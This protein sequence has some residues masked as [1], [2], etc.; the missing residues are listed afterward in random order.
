MIDYETPTEIDVTATFPTLPVETRTRKVQAGQVTLDES[1]SPFIRA[2]FTLPH[3]YDLAEDVSPLNGDRVLLTVK[4]TEYILR[5]RTF[6][7]QLRDRT[8]DHAA[9]TVTFE[10]SSDEMSLHDTARLAT[11]VD[12]SARANEADLGALVG[13]ALDKIGAT[14][15]PSTE[16]YPD[17][18]ARWDQTNLLPNPR[19]L[20]NVLGWRAVVPSGA[21]TINRGTTAFEPEGAPVSSFVYTRVTTATTGLAAVRFDTSE[22]MPIRVAESRMHTLSAWLYQDSGSTKTG[23]LWL[24]FKDDAGRTIRSATKTG[25]LPSGVWTKFTLTALSPTGTTTASGELGVSDGMPASK[26][27]AATAC[28]LAEGTE[29]DIWFDGD[30]PD[31]ADYDYSYSGEYPAVVS[32]RVARYPLDPEVFSWSPGQSLFEFL[33]PFLERFALVLYCDEQR[34]WYLEPP[35]IVRAGYWQ[36]APTGEF[37]GNVLESTDVTARDREDW[38]TGVVLRYSWRAENGDTKT[39]YDTAGT[40]G[41]VVTVDRN[42]PYPGAGGAQA[43]LDA[44]SRR[45]RAQ[46]VTILRGIL[47]HPGDTARIAMDDTEIQT[48][49]VRRVTLDLE[50]GNAELATVARD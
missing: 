42:E 13:W 47:A 50:T 28:V 9:G 12:K 38:A 7:L 15:E 25:S 39:A 36:V 14:L 29:N 11:T 10:A 27:V 24:A 44:M 26:L 43:I 8:I 46:A 16:I 22:T 23:R 2:S 20:G 34:R 21:G 6:D 33:R 31:D 49:R 19:A 1:Y 30:R 41:K 5:T 3:A 48:T 45:G 40:A 32:N 37:M 35:G 17:A 4:K 18:T